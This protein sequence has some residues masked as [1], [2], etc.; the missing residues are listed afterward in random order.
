MQLFVLARLGIGMILQKV[1]PVPH[2]YRPGKMHFPDLCHGQ[3]ACP[4]CPSVSPGGQAAPLLDRVIPAEIADQAVGELVQ[5]DGQ[6]PADQ[7]SPEQGVCVVDGRE[8]GVGKVDS[9]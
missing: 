5:H 2:K 6:D 9:W 4:C 7:E 1:I 8:H 3:L